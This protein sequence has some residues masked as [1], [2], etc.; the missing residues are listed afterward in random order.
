MSA[1]VIR[2][3]LVSY[4]IA[5]NTDLSSIA[6]E[7]QTLDDLINRA[8]GGPQPGNNVVMTLDLAGPRRAPCPAVAPTAQGG[9]HRQEIA[10]A[11]DCSAG[12]AK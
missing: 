12:T 7:P 6:G 9:D 2:A 4:G 5:N 1:A 11:L 3:D 8:K 10:R